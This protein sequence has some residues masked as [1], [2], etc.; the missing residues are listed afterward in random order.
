VETAGMSRKRPKNLRPSKAPAAV[1]SVSSGVSS[2]AAAAADDVDASDLAA[3][4]FFSAPPVTYDEEP[5]VPVEAEAV[6][7]RLPPSPARRRRL[8]RVVAGAVA[9]SCAICVAAGV[10]VATVRAA[11]MQAAAAREVA[12]APVPP[13]ET[14]SESTPPAPE[15]AVPE[16]P[17]VVEAP[18]AP[19]Q[20]A[21]ATPVA[22]APD[23]VAALDA[24]R[25]SQRALD[26]GNA[27]ASIEAGEQ[28]VALDP[29]DAEAW[30]ILGAAYQARGAYA[31]ARR[32]FSTC[33]HVAKRGPRGE[34]AAL[35]R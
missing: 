29:T 8:G 14:V 7:R 28:S 34:C 21:E 27:K 11:P 15:P 1:S 23:P 31:E 32:C 18:P 16:S 17:P 12:Q 3:A 19:P 35:L 20:A 22:A 5:V 10:R 25:T 24:K 2:R 33:A 30:L 26:R 6:A 9:L 4:H 13:V